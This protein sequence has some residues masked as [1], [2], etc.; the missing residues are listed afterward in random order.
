MTSPLPSA[1][2]F[3]TAPPQK[4]RLTASA[5]AGYFHH[6]CDRLFRWNTVAGPLHEK[7]GIGWGIPRKMRKYSRPGIN[8]LMSGGSRFEADHVTTLIEEHGE[9]NVLCAGV[10]R[11]AGTVNELDFTAVVTALRGKQIPKY[12]AQVKI[13]FSEEDEA[14][15]LR[16]F[17]LDPERVTLGVARPDLLE[18]HMA[19]DCESLL[20]RIWDFKMSQ[21]ARHDHFMQVAFYTYMLEHALVVYGLPHVR[22]DVHTAVIRSRKVDPEEFELAPYRLAVDDFLRNHARHLFD[23][24]ARSAHFHVADH[25][26]NCEYLDECRAQ[27]D[28]GHDLSC[29]PYM[30]SESKRRLVQAGIRNYVDL[31]DLDDPARIESIRE[32]GHDLSVNLQRYIQNA[33]ALWDGNM[34]DMEADTL[35]MPY[36]ESVRIV[37]SAESDPVTATCFALGF[38]TFQWDAVNNQPL[39][40]SHVVVSDGPEKE[41]ELLVHFLRPLNE[42]LQG[43]DTQNRNI[44]SE[45]PDSDPRVIAALERVAAGNDAYKAFRAHTPQL[46]STNPNFAA[47]NDEV[48]T[49]QLEIRQAAEALK[50]ARK[51]AKWIRKGDTSHFTFTCTIG[52]ISPFCAG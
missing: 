45:S 12:I 2:T 9:E 28:V 3:Q 20:L 46:R 23:T 48:N 36:H 29:I 21:E 10:D 41:A 47:L 18:I 35:L 43:I 1:P 24:P 49:I 39:T 30:S 8:L 44:F 26:T 52:L 5:V 15:F 31:V 7:P 4:F 19:E 50:Q 13:E 25:C 34:R 6:S 11:K 32:L 33:R 16:H 22:V 37:L 51:D 42:F 38:R 17:G 14:D 40:S 27:A